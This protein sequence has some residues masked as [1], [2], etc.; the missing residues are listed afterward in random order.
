MKYTTI[1][2]DFDDTIVDFYNA[3]EKAFYN[4]AK[5]FNHYPTEEDFYYFRKVNQSHWEA[6]QENKLTKVEVLTLRF[7]NYFKDYNI[8]V[9][10]NLADNLFRD[11]LAKATPSFFDGT[12]DTIDYLRKKHNIYIVTNGV[13]ETQQRRLAQTTFN[14]TLN[15]IFISEQT[16]YQKP[17][18]EFFDYIFKEMGET[19]RE[20]AIIVGDSLTSDILGGKNANI[21]TC[22]FN[23]RNKENNTTIQPDYEIKSLKELIDIVE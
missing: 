8:E 17:M 19:H 12:L 10:G 1:L 16:G 2:L 21:A 14:E 22:W 7:V 3:E 5:H 9:D 23:L 11:E 13:T 20:K 4:M 6:F 15:G 18:P